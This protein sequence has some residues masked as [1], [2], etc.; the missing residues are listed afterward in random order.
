M[1]DERYKYNRI[2]TMIIFLK[3]PAFYT[4]V[5]IH[6]PYLFLIRSFTPKEILTHLIENNEIAFQ[7]LTF[8]HITPFYFS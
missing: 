7:A 2:K 1:E 3:Y 8:P 6:G 5:L 4:P